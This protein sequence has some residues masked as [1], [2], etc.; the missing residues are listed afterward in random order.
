MLVLL[1]LLGCFLELL[2][3]ADL[4]AKRSLRFC[5]GSTDNAITFILEQRKAWEEQKQR[6][7]P[8]TPASLLRHCLPAA[9]GSTRSWGVCA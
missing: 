4:Q 8:H 7:D 6:C 5:Q 1:H 2:G 3:C 9:S